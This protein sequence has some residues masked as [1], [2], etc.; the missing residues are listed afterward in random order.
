VEQGREREGGWPMG[1][2]VGWGLAHG[3]EGGYDRWSPGKENEKEEKKT[4]IKSNLKLV[5][6]IYSNLI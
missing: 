4:E 2:P 3:G 6:E 1:H 5:I